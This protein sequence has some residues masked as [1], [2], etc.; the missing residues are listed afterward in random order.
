MSVELEIKLLGRGTYVGKHLSFGSGGKGLWG[1]AVAANRTRENRLSG[2][3][4]GAC[5]NVGYGSQAEAHRETW[6]IS[7]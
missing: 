7:H 4:E 3:R 2:M 5:G 6:W 1:N